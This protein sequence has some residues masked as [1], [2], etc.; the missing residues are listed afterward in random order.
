MEPTA[1]LR[2]LLHKIITSMGPMTHGKQNSHGFSIIMFL[3]V[4]SLFFFSVYSISFLVVP[5]LKAFKS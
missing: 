4:L 5:L 3:W 1:L 2:R